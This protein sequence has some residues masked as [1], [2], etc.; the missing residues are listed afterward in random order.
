VN[1]L[2]ICAGI[3]WAKDAHQV[4]VADPDGQPLW[5]EN[6]PHTEAGID[7]LCRTL[8]TLGVARVAIERPDGLLIERL[9]DTGLT[10]LAIHPNKV[11]A[12]RDRFRAA[13]GKSDRF[14]AFVL[15][16]LART[17]SH[18]FAVLSPDSDQTKA[19][20]AL[21]RGR[22]VL[23]QQRVAVC[24]Q[25]RAELE[26]FWPGAATIFSDL[27][28]PISLAFLARYPSPTDTRGLGEKRLAQFLARHQYSGKRSPADL[29]TRLRDAP[30]GRAADLEADARRGLVLALVAA[31]TPLVEQIRLLT[32]EIAHAVRTHPDGHI[33]LSFFKD[34]KSVICAA[35]LLAEIGNDRA[36]YPTAE[37][38]A[39]DAGMT[40]VAVE[41]GRKKVACFRRGCDH[42]LRAATST[43]ADATRH[44]NTWAA[45]HY[46]RARG[47]GHDHPR[48]I[49]TLGRAWTRVLWRCW[50]D[51][52]AYDPNR[53]NALQRHLEIINPNARG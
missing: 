24:N 21:T 10:V 1:D 9:L 25:L 27:D 32:S 42:R 22:E 23:V 50:Q 40:P 51:G 39:A 18:R 34:P 13:G 38:L 52:V 19:L 16:E 44:H 47:R 48:A 53:H 3:D 31:L 29:L 46:A 37:A 5:S 14:D 8:L 11:A 41:S 49:R 12:A 35:T 30:T 43:L 15:C 20:R 7:R 26:R 2:T 17:D 36:R 6:V 33:F 4:L 45:D 28:S